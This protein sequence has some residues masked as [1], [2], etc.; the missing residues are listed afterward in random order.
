MPDAHEHPGAQRHAVD[1]P[2]VDVGAVGAAEVDQL[3]AAGAVGAQLGVVARDQEVADDDVV[4]GLAADPDAGGGGPGRGCRVGGGGRDARGGRRL[5]VAGGGRSSRRSGRR[6]P[7]HRGEA[8][9]TARSVG[10]DVVG[11]RAGERVVPGAGRGAGLGG[12]RTGIGPGGTGRGWDEGRGHRHRRGAGVGADRPERDL[13]LGPAV[14]E[15][16][17]EPRRRPGR[18]PQLLETLPGDEHAVAAVVD[19]L[20]PGGQRPQLDVDT[21]DEGVHHLEPGR[22]VAADRDGLTRGDHEPAV[23]V[24]EFEL[25]SRERPAAGG[26]PSPRGPGHGFHGVH[27]R[28]PHGPARDPA[29]H[30]TLSPSRRSGGPRR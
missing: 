12:D 13:H 18:E 10:T 26:S 6:Q 5:G 9:L 25:R 3:P 24:R 28:P 11:G 8:P 19:Q 20:P 23:T 21:G 29:P 22:L 2:A 15:R 30:T 4:V 1:A 14:P 17:R 16:E 27:G 7:V